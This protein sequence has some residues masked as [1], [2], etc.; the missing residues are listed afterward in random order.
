MSEVVLAV[1]LPRLSAVSALDPPRAQPTCHVWSVGL[2]EDGWVGSQLQPQAAIS[3][4][5][6][7]QLPRQKFL[8]TQSTLPSSFLNNIC[9]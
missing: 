2:K 7:K 6:R 1:N 4:G 9:F 8:P 3:P 5:T